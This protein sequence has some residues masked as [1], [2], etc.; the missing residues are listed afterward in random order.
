MRRSCSD[1]DFFSDIRDSYVKVAKRRQTASGI[2]RQLE[3]QG[4]ILEPATAHG[5]GIATSF[6]G[7]AWCRA[8]EGWQDYE[9]RLPAGRSLLK[10]G[11][12]IDLKIERAK[13]SAS[14]AADRL[15]R[16]Q[17]RF[18]DADAERMDL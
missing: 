14:V 15:Y 6:W 13:V 5:K 16:V 4:E 10:N 3:A 9:S 7:R 17:I 2:A 8:I 12:V 11:G 18:A 1:D